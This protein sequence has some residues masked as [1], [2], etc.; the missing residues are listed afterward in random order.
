MTDWESVLYALHA[1]P[2][3]LLEDMPA[4]V[5]LS[6]SDGTI[7]MVNEAACLISGCGRSDM[8]GQTWP[9]PWFL[10]DWRGEGGNPLD[11]LLQSGNVLASE[12]TCV[13]RLGEHRALSVTMSLLTGESGQTQ[14][15]LMV[16]QDIT[17][18]KRWEEGL[19][20]AERIRVVSQLASGVA[21]DINN[22]LAVILGYSEYL[23]AKS[24]NLDESERH[25]LDAIQK[26]AQG[27]AETVRRIQV[28][29]RRVPRDKFT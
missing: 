24:E 10:D 22:D 14:R 26:Q 29:A 3:Q 15:V 12:V 21:H 6:Q 19:V 23:L 20:Q 5:Q 8:I 13:T 1:T 11:E 7:E 27:C 18:R 28:F 9:Y 17:Q 2:V 4:W 25:A 16:A